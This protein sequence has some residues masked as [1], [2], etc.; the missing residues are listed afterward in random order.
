IILVA[1]TVISLVA[2][3]FTVEKSAAKAFYLPQYRFWELSLGALLA[4]AALYAGDHHKEWLRRR[5]ERIGLSQASFASIVS[6]CGLL[7]ILVAALLFSDRM[8]YP[9]AWALVPTLGALLLIA[10]GPQG[11]INRLVLSVP[12][13]VFVGLISYPLYLW[14]WPLLSFRSILGVPDD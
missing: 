14:H 5:V 10:A 13:V 12:A 8:L 2:N 7:L 6:C 4:F 11:I 3:I 1:I 9:G